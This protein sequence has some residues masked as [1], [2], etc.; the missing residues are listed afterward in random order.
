MKTRNERKQAK[1]RN[2]MRREFRSRCH[3]LLDE[4]LSEQDSA[5]GIQRIDSFVG[6]SLEG[7]L[8]QIGLIVTPPEPKTDIEERAKA[9]GIEIVKA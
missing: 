6:A 9:S 7:C 5:N 1:M 8:I 4:Y 3:M 2:R